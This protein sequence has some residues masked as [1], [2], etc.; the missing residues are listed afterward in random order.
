V[1]WGCLSDADPS[2]N[3]FVGPR[4]FNEHE[5]KFVIVPFALD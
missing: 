5:S 1:M 4:D 3:T 2:W